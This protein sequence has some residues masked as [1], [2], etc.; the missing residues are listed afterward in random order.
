M[1]NK[2]EQLTAKNAIYQD[3]LNLFVQNW[4]EPKTVQFSVICRVPFIDNV[5]KQSP[6]T[7]ELFLHLKLL[8]IFLALF[9]FVWSLFLKIKPVTLEIW[10]VYKQIKTKKFGM[11]KK[12]KIV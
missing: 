12:S 11:F 8:N 7:S 3:Y 2:S 5:I 10:F 9:R 1:I 4:E 6:F